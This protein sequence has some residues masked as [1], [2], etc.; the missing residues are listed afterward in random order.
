MQPREGSRL[1]SGRMRSSPAIGLRLSVPGATLGAL[2]GVVLGLLVAAVACP[3]PPADPCNADSDCDAERVCAMG[4]CVAPTAPR[5]AGGAAADGGEVP[6][7]GE[8]DDA[9]D[10]GDAGDGDA[11][12]TL[13]AGTAD[14]GAADAGPPDAGGC[15]PGDHDGGDGSCVPT[16]SCSPGYTRWY[17]DEDHDGVGEGPQSDDCAAEPLQVGRALVDGDCEPSDPMRF[18]LQVGFDDTDLDGYT[19]GPLSLC[20][21]DV[22]A[23]GV[24]AEAHGA[25]LLA[26]GVA[27][28]SSGS[29]NPWSN[30]GNGWGCCGGVTTADLDAAADTAELVVSDFRCLAVPARLDR[31]RALA[32][33]RLPL[34]T[35]QPHALALSVTL[36]DNGVPLTALSTTTTWLPSTFSLVEIE[37]TPAEWGLQNPDPAALCAGALDL[38][39][40]VLQNGDY[41]NSVEIDYVVLELLGAD[42]CDP[43]NPG[44]YSPLNLYDDGDNDDSFGGTPIAGCV[45]DGQRE[46]WVPLVDQDCDDTD[47]RA[48]PGQTNYY[49]GQRNSGGW[50]YDCNGSEDKRTYADATGC[51]E[52]TVDP[53]VCVE[54]GSANRTGNCG[55]SVDADRCPAAAPCALIQDTATQA[56]R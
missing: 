45:G 17:Q 2:L 52:D 3:G 16:G 35:L 20:V 23:P 32:R 48:H 27:S 15:G 50:D 5:D 13:D 55:G 56:C 14:G 8:A 4:L 28:S 40:A 34:T 49:T 43:A 36:V 22:P 41:A 38:R 25:P 30:P 53:T 19:A 1:S 54:T 21:G 37:A 9:D 39:V 44:F 42:D 18:Q 29:N 7:A 26:F 11:G 6:D 47:S 24:V 31:I 10:A 12:P 51:A 33:V 46:D